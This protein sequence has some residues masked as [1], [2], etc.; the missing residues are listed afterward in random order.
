M[1]DTLLLLAAVAV[2]IGAVCVKLVDVIIRRADV[3]AGTLLAATVLGMAL[4][5]ELLALPLGSFNVFLMDGVLAIITSAAIA[6]HL[7]MQRLPVA[8]R[9][10][11][12]VLVLTV[13]SLARGVG[14]I[15]VQAAVND[16]RTFLGFVGAAAYFMTFS[17]PQETLDRIARLV[18][19]AAMAVGVLV[20]IRWFGVVTGASIGVLGA[21]Y[22]APIRVLSGPE[23]FFL[24]IALFLV[25]PHWIDGNAELWQRWLGGGLLVMVTL[26]NRRTVWLAVVVGLAVVVF[27]RQGIGGR[28]R[29]LLAL[30]AVIAS[31]V[32]FSLPEQAETDVGQSAT[33]TG[34]LSWR[35]EGW[36]SLLLDNGPERPSEWLFGMPMGSG[37]EREVLSGRGD[38]RSVDSSPHSFYI[39]VL[40]RTGIVGVASV[41]IVFALTLR[42]LIPLSRSPAFRRSGSLITPEVM[43]IVVVMQLIWFATWQ[44]GSEQGLITGLALA[45]WWSRHRAPAPPPF[46]ADHAVP[47]GG[48]SLPAGASQR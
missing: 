27:R 29:P 28:A 48:R 45:M 11:L 15:G 46:H 5:G 31:V 32:F 47:P 13:L 19:I 8:L 42:R 14:D 20:C 16:F 3:A 7:R 30:A 21:E 17:G 22:D 18:L 24:A 6:R 25:L 4:P 23:T 33:N 41:L 36:S 38:I 1:S 40:L 43:L 10:L 37:Y 26:L 9:L 34:T 44:V 35:I 39:Q 12:V 2:V